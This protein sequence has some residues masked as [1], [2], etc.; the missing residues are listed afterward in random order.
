MLIGA[1]LISIDSKTLI[2]LHYIPHKFFE[3]VRDG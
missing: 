3:S 2:D 1:P